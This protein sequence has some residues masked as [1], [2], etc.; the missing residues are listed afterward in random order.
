MDISIEQNAGYN[1]QTE[2]TDLDY[3]S[4]Q[5]N[6]DCNINLNPHLDNTI[7][8]GINTKDRNKLMH[9][10]REVKGDIIKLNK[11]TKAQS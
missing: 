3:H 11:G 5:D 4:H 2:M 9:K 1:F 10:H 8:H 6:I 7:K